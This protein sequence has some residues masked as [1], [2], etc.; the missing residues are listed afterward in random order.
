MSKDKGLSAGSVGL[1]GAITIGLACVAPPYTLTGALGPTA[2]AVG[3]QVPAIILIGF[4]PMLLTAFGYREL[5]NVMPDSGTS[6]TWGVRA[7]GPYVG[8]LSGWGLIVATCVV[9]SNIAGIAVDFFFLLISQ[10]VSQEWSPWVASLTRDPVINIAT[11]L[12]FMF[13]ATFISYRDMQ[14]TQ[15]IQYI[16]VSLQLL[17]FI[18]FGCVM[19]YEGYVLHVPNFSPIEASWFNPLEVSSFGTLA[20][21]ISISLFI[22]WGWDVTLTMNEETKGASSTPGKAATWTVVI[23]VFIYLFV[24]LGAM[25]YAGTGT[26]G[27]GLGNPDIQNN[28]FFALA[29]PVFGS[30]AALISLAVLTSSAASLQSTFVSP[31]RTLLAMGHY[32]AMSKKFARIHPRFFTPGYATIFSAIATSIFYT[33]MRILSEKVLW[34]TVQTLGIMICFYYGLTAYSCV[35]YFRKKWFDSFRNAMFMLFMPLIG[36]MILTWLFVQTIVESMD[37]EFGSGSQIFHIGLVFWLAIL[38]IGLGI[39]IMVYQRLRYPDFFFGKT[40]LSQGIADDKQEQ[41]FAE[42]TP[43]SVTV[44]I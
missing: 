42:H 11:C 10:L 31:A 40:G 33:V 5:N 44:D 9:L 1:L 35:W 4:I 14:T 12:I 27:I 34:D 26:T 8:W 3:H 16:L 22:F 18:G 17:I 25:V 21:G 32:G 38:L 29:N 2:A 6:F 37:P 41:E 19:F 36:A 23:V 13:L 24:S 28:V 39:V 30:F 7:F 15:R 43:E 20:T